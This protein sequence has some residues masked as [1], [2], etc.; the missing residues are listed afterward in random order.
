VIR[1]SANN[2]FVEQEVKERS[3]ELTKEFEEY[4]QEYL[5]KIGPDVVEHKTVVYQAWS[6]QKIASL[7]LCVEYIAESV[8]ACIIE[9]K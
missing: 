9:E 2:P 4:F 1:S 7:Q 8:R 6:I 5:D 3:E